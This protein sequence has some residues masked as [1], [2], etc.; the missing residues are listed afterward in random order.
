MKVTQSIGLFQPRIADVRLAAQRRLLRRTR[1]KRSQS[2]ADDAQT[3]GSARRT[4]HQPRALQVFKQR[5][6]RH[7]SVQFLSNSKKKFKY[8][9]WPSEDIRVK[10]LSFL[11][12]W[13][14]AGIDSAAQQQ[15][16]EA[17]LLRG[18]C[19]SGDTRRLHQRPITYSFYFFILIELNP[20]LNSNNLNAKLNVKKKE[21]KI[22]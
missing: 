22:N 4:G 6:R 15:S 19:P 7:Q 12:Q 18:N 2:D 17:H 13:T 1:R 8:S 9:N 14:D 21:I 16:R 5:V 10:A 11:Q 20:E 3:A